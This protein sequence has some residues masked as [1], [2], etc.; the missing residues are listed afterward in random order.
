MCGAGKVGD[1]C[2]IL[3][4]AGLYCYVVTVYPAGVGRASWL[5]LANGQTD[6]SLSLKDDHSRM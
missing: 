1:H 2:F 3:L 4:K 6:L 5:G